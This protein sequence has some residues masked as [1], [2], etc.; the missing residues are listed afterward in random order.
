MQDNGPVVH[1]QVLP[2]GLATTVYC[3]IGRPPSDSGGDHVAVAEATPAVAATF[4]GAV[5]LPGTAAFDGCDGSDVPVALV[6]VTVNV[7]DT[8]FVNPLTVHDNGPVVQVHCAPPGDAVTVYPVIVE[9]PV[10]AGAD[11]DTVAWLSPGTPDA[12]VGEPGTVIGGGNA[13]IILTRFPE[14]K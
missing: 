13:W 1:T 12:P 9:P 5:G 14:R 11:H 4:C 10:H 6:A 8:P 7:Y 3:V 2:P